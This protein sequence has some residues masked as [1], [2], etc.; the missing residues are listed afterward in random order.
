MSVTSFNLMMTSNLQSFQHNYYIVPYILIMVFP[1]RCSCCYAQLTRERHVPKNC[2]NPAS[3]QA[4]QAIVC[5]LCLQHLGQFCGSSKGWWVH[6]QSVSLKF[7]GKIAFILLGLHLHMWF[8][9]SFTFPIPFPSSLHSIILSHPFT[10][11]IL[12]RMVTNLC[13]KYWK[14]ASW[15]ESTRKATLQW[16]TKL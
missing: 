4:H 5:Y 7:Q 3:P 12:T 13:K 16:R 14:L 8:T 2:W 10:T 11:L 15:C 9:Y 6:R 1:N